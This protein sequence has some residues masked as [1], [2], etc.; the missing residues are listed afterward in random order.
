MRSHFVV[1]LPASALF[2]SACASLPDAAPPYSPAPAA[3][4]GYATVYFYRVG[5]YP[6]LRRPDILIS[7]VPI[8][9]PPELAYTWVHV[10]AGLH[11]FKAQWA[12]DTRWPTVEF[13][14]DLIAGAS[15]Y[16]KLS[17]SF[18]STGM[19]FI[20]GSSLQPIDSVRAIYE[21]T[22]CCKYI[23]PKVQHVP[24]LNSH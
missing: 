10:K 1:V 16:Y 9:E 12:W 14:Q 18:E 8:Y 23:P 5:A 6:S 7:G 22:K 20:L 2:L 13:K 15:Y 17:G 11:T 3:S 21:L 24:S 19:K 4:D